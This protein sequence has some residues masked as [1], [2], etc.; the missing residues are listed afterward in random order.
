[1]DLDDKG[2]KDIP[3]K[4]CDILDPRSFGVLLAQR[5]ANFFQFIDYLKNAKEGCGG[6][7]KTP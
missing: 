3:L 6:G 2:S 4:Y 7:L 5:H 1:M